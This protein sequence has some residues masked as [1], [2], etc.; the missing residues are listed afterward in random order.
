MIPKSSPLADGWMME[1]ETR[2]G[3]GLAW[4][5]TGPGADPTFLFWPTHI[6]HPSRIGLKDRETPGHVTVPA[7]S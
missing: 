1:L 5:Q 7:G 4:G 2:L 3:K 6:V